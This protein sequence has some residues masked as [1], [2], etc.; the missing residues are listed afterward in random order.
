[1][2]RPLSQVATSIL[3]LFIQVFL[4]FSGISSSSWRERV[5]AWSSASKTPRYWLL[6]RQVVRES[7]L[8]YRGDCVWFRWHQQQYG[9]YGIIFILS[10][11]PTSEKLEN[12]DLFLRI[13]LPPTLIHREKWVFWKRSSNQRN[14]KNSG[15]RFRLPR[16]LFRVTRV[17]CRLSRVLFTP[18]G[19]LFR[20]TRTLFSNRNAIY[21]HSR[22]SP[23]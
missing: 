16:V 22:T 3:F 4:F 20:P 15:L 23:Q 7:L 1:M 19:T 12:A 10:P 6:W 5:L 9:K 8:W 14:S 13:G 18:T 2:C 11:S 17:L 21:S